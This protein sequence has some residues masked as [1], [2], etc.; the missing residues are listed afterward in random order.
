MVTYVCVLRLL[1]NLDIE[2]VDLSSE[3]G[4]AIIQNMASY[5]RDLGRRSICNLDIVSLDDTMDD[6]GMNVVDGAHGREG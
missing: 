2:T 5:G 3:N 4:E 6:V 1:C